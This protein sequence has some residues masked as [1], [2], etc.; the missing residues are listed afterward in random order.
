M[1][2][3]VI[4]AAFGRTGTH[5]FQRAMEILGYGK[6]YH[7][8]EVLKN[9]HGSTWVQIANET[10]ERK[11]KLIQDLM[12]QNGYRATS[13][14]PASLFWREQLQIYPD[15]KVVI[16]VRDPLSWYESWINTIALMCPDAE[17]CSL[18]TRVSL[19]LGLHPLKIGV[20]DL[21]REITRH[22]F[23]DDWSKENMI[24]CY[25]EHIENVKK[26]CPP[27]QLLLFKASDGWEPLCTFLG[28]PIPDE[29]YPYLHDTKEFQSMASSFNMIGWIVTILGL[30]IPLLFRTHSVISDPL[31]KS[32]NTK[33]SSTI[34]VN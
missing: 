24:K 19:G 28:L 17:E 21:L 23:N 34:K 26:V 4:N 10:N 18:G 7:M 30:G 2:I 14:M 16:T 6:C 13:D 22:A 12:E 15:A 3:E 32:T 1:G 11:P 8:E 5:S 9:N 33:Y 29:P 25:V 31:K 20:A 27:N